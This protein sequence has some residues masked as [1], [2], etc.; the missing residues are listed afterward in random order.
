MPRVA[1]E[2]GDGLCAGLGQNYVD[3]LHSD[4]PRN[5]FIGVEPVGRARLERHGDYLP[6]LAE[7]RN[8]LFVQSAFLPADIPEALAPV[9][10]RRRV[11]VLRAECQ[12]ADHSVQ[13]VALINVVAVDAQAA[14]TQCRNHLVQ[15]E[16]CVLQHDVEF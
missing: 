1:A 9:F 12:C 5:L 10:C 4:V 3:P 14:S 15:V 13:Q 8:Q 2:G 11:A 7:R 6:R 16:P